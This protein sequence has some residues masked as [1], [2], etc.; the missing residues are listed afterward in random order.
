MWQQIQP[1]KKEAEFFQREGTYYRN[2]KLKDEI[3]EQLVLL[4]ACR[5]PVLQMAHAIP[6]AGH[7]GRKKTTERVLQ[8][9]FWPGVSKDVAEYCRN[10][11][12]CQKAS[13]KRVTPAPLIPLPVIAEPFS[14]IA[15]DIVGS[16][17]S[18]R[19]GNHFVL[20]ICDYATRY[21]EAIPLRS[22]DAEHVAEQLVQVFS[23]GDPSG[24]YR[25]FFPFELLY[26]RSVRGP[27][28]VLK[29]TWKAREKTNE[30]VLFYL[31]IMRERLEKMSQL[32]QTNT[33]QAQQGQKTWYDKHARL[34]SFEP[35]DKVLVLLPTDTSKFLAQWKGPYPVVKRVSD[36]LH[37]VDMIGT[38]KRN[39]IFHINMLKR[40]NEVKSLLYFEEDDADEESLD[41]GLSTGG[42]LRSGES[43]YQELQSL[44][45]DFQDVLQGKPGCTRLIEHS[46]LTGS[47]IPVRQA[48]Y[49][50]PYAHWEWV[51]KDME[52][53]L[54]DGVIEPSMSDWACPI[55]LIDGGI[56]FCVD[57]GLL[58][59]ETGTKGEKLCHYRKGVLVQGC[60]SELQGLPSGV[61]VHCSDRP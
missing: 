27:L 17:P 11:S 26:G 49:R 51:K 30:S 18:S 8:R 19:S 20:V 52:A 43:Q 47:S 59:S 15:L 3:V 23:R 29:E 22:V 1:W 50:L 10:C 35:G 33:S 7:L 40:W 6:M 61:Q 57:Y 45:S 42:K 34:R 21:P 13:S 37:E 56:R 46:I 39:C 31:M 9:F 5:D 28:D 12:S 32:A 25:I 2:R 60:N 44:W 24:V 41:S 55:V 53:M 36:V 4:K 54:L 48:P 14:R 58:Q 38:Q 16:L